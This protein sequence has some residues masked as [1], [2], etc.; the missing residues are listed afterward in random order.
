MSEG[1]YEQFKIN[2]V[3]EFSI[4]LIGA[5]IEDETGKDKA[6]ST[7]EEDQS[8]EATEN[9]EEAENGEEEEFDFL[10]EYMQANEGSKKDRVE[11]LEVEEYSVSPTGLL[12]IKLSKPF[13]KP[14]LI[15]H[16]ERM[17]A[18]DQRYYDINEIIKLEVK[19][20]EIDLDDLERLGITSYNLT[21]ISDQ[22]IEVQ[23]H[24][25]ETEIISQDRVNPEIL[26]VR[27]IL[28][29]IFVDKEDF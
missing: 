22:S 24:F 29:H 27:F 19:S 3:F 8:Q 6:E 25:I 12:F 14:P 2:R 17:L 15:L 4:D 10:L 28:G 23:I 7:K 18:S 9:E 11:P 16:E 21:N 1:E 20:T 5:E 26:D 13:I